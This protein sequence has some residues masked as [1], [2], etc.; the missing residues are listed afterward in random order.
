MPPISFDGYPQ[1]LAVA[2]GLPINNLDAPSLE[3]FKLTPI[4]GHLAVSPHDLSIPPQFD[5]YD[6]S[7][8]LH[9]TVASIGDFKCGKGAA[10]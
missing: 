8:L 1:R 6:G 5:P 2:Y 3:I 4:T 10:L 9:D 7:T